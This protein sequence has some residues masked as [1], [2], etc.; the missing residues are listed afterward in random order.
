MLFFTYL[1][2]IFQ[3]TKG[4]VE[5]NRKVSSESAPGNLNQLRNGSE[6]SLSGNSE[7]SVT[8]TQLSMSPGEKRKQ[9]LIE[10]SKIGLHSFKFLKVIGKGSFGKVCVD[11]TFD[12]LF[13]NSY[14]AIVNPI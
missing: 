11:S 1:C 8:K 14:W 2:S 12:R 5:H 7:I 4:S 13:R 6:I 3:G 9:M 10:Q